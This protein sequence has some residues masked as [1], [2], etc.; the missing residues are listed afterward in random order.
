MGAARC[1]AS[2]LAIHRFV[3]PEVAASV[4]WPCRAGRPS[5]RCY[6]CLL[7]GLRPFATDRGEDHN[8]P[9]QAECWKPSGGLKAAAMASGLVKVGLFCLMMR[10]CFPRVF[11]VPAVVIAGVLYA[12][13]CLARFQVLLDRA[14]GEVAITVGLWTK[15][16]P[17]TRI[18]RVEEVLRFGAEI[19]IAGGVTFTFSPFRRRR[20][21]ARLLKIRTGFEGM[22]L[23]ITQA[24]AAA[25]AADPAGAAATKAAAGAAQSRRTIPAACVV[26]GCGVFLLAV[27][28]AVAVQ[29]Q[30]GG[31]LVHSVAVLLQI[32]YGTGGVAALLSGAWVLH[33]ALRDRRAAGQQG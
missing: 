22:E 31:W 28:V 27:A 21:L 20:R 8:L 16:V 25:R 18:E 19:E 23:A 12:A 26:C 29:P 6:R 3:G 30:A 24:A 1:P 13:A 2:T 5:C 9:V 7:A 14:A 11:L 15:R 33:S 4:V 17:L 10:F 32:F